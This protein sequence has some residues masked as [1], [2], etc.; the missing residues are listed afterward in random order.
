MSLPIIVLL[1]NM[2]MLEYTTLLRRFDS[3]MYGETKNIA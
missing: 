1:K 3:L 2:N